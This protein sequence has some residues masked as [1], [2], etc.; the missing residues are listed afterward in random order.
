MTPRQTRLLLACPLI[1]FAALAFVLA[2]G[3][4][5]GRHDIHPSSLLGRSLPQFELTTLLDIQPV[6]NEE[7]VGRVRLMNVWASWC[8][9]CR[10]E[11]NVLK[12]IAEA[13][14]VSLIG[15]NYKDTRGDAV[16]WLYELGNP[17]EFNIVD[18][19]GDFG[20]DLGV[21]GAP[22]TFLVD[23]KGIIRYKHVGP[24]TEETWRDKIRPLLA[25]LK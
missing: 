4:N 7:V 25:T 21:Y 18:A 23:S 13:N 22:E 8:V 9:A 14:E 15:I 1:I 24:L 16:T 5:L 19:N 17:F 3:F 12:Q 6:S 10:A 2:I 11:H 20:V